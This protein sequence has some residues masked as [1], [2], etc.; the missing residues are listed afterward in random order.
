MAIR[1][2][3]NHGFVRLA[4]LVALRLQ[5][6]HPLRYVPAR[7]KHPAR[8]AVSGALPECWDGAV[9]HLKFLPFAVHIQ[10]TVAPLNIDANGGRRQILR[11]RF[12]WK[13]ECPIARQ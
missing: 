8:L 11:W 7:V 5:V 9:D 6:T 2:V 1:P 4:A 3:T 10:G 12:P 13:V